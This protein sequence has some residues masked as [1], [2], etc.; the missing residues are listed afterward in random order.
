LD[1]NSSEL[2]TYNSSSS[3]AAYLKAKAVDDKS[4]GCFL[5][6]AKAAAKGKPLP[7][8]VGVPLEPLVSGLNPSCNM[9]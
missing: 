3:H 1:S 7:L 5:V 9:L 6:G 4:T 2:E 8:A